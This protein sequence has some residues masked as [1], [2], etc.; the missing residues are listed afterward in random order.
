MSKWCNGSHNRLRFFE[1]YS[2]NIIRDVVKFG[3]TCNDGNAEL[4]QREPLI[5]RAVVRCK[6]VTIRA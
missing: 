4:S 3:E 1:P 6:G 5:F 2:G